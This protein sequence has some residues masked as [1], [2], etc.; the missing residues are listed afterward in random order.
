MT[1]K[2]KYGLIGKNISY[3]FSKNYFLKKFEILKLENFSYENFDIP[4]IDRL[5]L[6]LDENRNSLKGLNI[7]IPYKEEI[8]K[9][10]DEVDN[11]AEAIGAVNTV[12]ILDNK[13]PSTDMNKKFQKNTFTPHCILVSCSLKF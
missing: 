3:S 9:Y 8:I 1:K 2:I 5:P 10:L 11:D 7:T 13:N 6:I 12:K 4:T